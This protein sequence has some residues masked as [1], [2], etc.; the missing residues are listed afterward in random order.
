MNI[1]YKLTN[2]SKTEGK[3]FYIGSKTECNIIELNSIPTIISL[4]NSKPY[5]GSSSCNQFKE[6]F[7]KGDVFKAEI[8]DTVV[9]RKDLLEKENQ[10][11][12]DNNAV[13]S[14]DYY[15][16]SYAT[17]DYN[18]DQ[19]A[20]NNIFGETIKEVANDRSRY[21]KNRSSVVALGFDHVWEFI[22][23]VDTL[24]KDKK[25]FSE[26]ASLYN[27]KRHFIERK[28]RSYD[29]ERFYKERLNYQN[30]KKLYLTD[31]HL[32]REMI[33]LNSSYKN[34]CKK[35]NISML[36]LDYL[37][38]NWDQISK[39]HL[40]ASLRNLTKE[41]LSIKIVKL[42]LE[43]KSI[44]EASTELKLDL[45]TGT[46]YFLDYIRSNLEISEL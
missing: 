2:T 33:N 45:T 43:G 18:Y 39:T 6:D 30:N 16:L 31:I 42:V 12:T 32:V 38:D 26:I 17:L 35:L 1:I 23:H 21:S 44:K 29:I 24:R 3:R 7:R 46:R 8:L 25:T 14:E 41:E 15:N 34:I 37:S 36:T 20:I 5:Y 27:K 11:I 9:H 19:S 40:N 4:K 22:E 13:E 28:Y 10:Y